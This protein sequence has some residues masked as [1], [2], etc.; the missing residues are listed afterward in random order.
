MGS[1]CVS[2]QRDL[3][4]SQAFGAPF[5]GPELPVEDVYKYA[6]FKQEKK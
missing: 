4:L 2:E 6:Y 5:A 3:R 1:P